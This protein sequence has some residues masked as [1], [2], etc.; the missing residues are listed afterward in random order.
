MCDDVVEDVQDFVKSH[1]SQLQFL[2]IPPALF[3]PLAKQLKK[4]LV[5]VDDNTLDAQALVSQSYANF[6]SIPSS[7]IGSLLVIPHL[8]S[9]DMVAEPDRG[10]WDAL[11]PLPLSVLQEV[12]RALQKLWNETSDTISDDRT[13]L[14]NRIC[15]PRTWSRVMLYREEGSN[16]VRG[17]LPSPPYPPQ[18]KVASASDT[19]EADLTGPF[20]FRYES[21]KFPVD[22]SMVYVCP[23]LTLEPGQLPTIDL[24]PIYSAP[25]AQMRAVRYAALLGKDAPDFALTEV[26]G[27]YAN[28]VKNMHQRRQQALEQEASEAAPP[29]RSNAPEVAVDKIWKVYTDANDPMELGHPEAGLS[30]STFQLTTSLEDADIIYSY[31]SLFAPG[32]LKDSIDGRTNVLINQFPYEGA[33]VQKDHLGREIL[34]QHGLPLPNWAIETYDLDVQFTE[35]VGAATLAAER[36]EDDAIWI[37]KPASGTQSKGHV[38]TKSTAQ[39][40]RMTDTGGGSRVAQRYIVSLLCA[41]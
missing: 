14:L 16:R 29:E 22:C 5:P 31:Q 11:A 39:V 1:A 26:R 9:W 17:A 10:M 15:D 35:F 34:R 36:G 41:S 27:L 24:V 30:P 2:N 13:A 20:P 40:L 12:L 28:F 37:I 3:E 33:F 8:C 6:S 25:N 23:S 7:D 19:T 18:L 32:E 21:L 4:T 38:V